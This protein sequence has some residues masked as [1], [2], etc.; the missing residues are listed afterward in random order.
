MNHELEMKK[1]HWCCLAALLV[2]SVLIRTYPLF[3]YS[4][5]GTD[6]GEYVYY[7]HRWIESGSMHRSID[8]WAQAYPF[9]PGIFCL[10]GAFHLLTGVN[11]HGSVSTAPIALSLLTPLLIF[12]VVH[13]IT[14]QKNMALLSAALMTFFA[15]I[16]YNYSQPKPETLGFF[17]M[18]FLLWMLFIT[19]KENLGKMLV[20]I[21]PFSG[22]LVITHHLSSLFLILLTLGGYFF[23]EMFRTR[24]TWENRFRAWF[25]V[26]FST[27][28][29]AYWFYGAPPFRDERFLGAMGLPSY[30]ILLAPYIAFFMAFVLIRA[31][32]LSIVWRPGIDLRGNEFKERIFLSMITS[33]IVIFILIYSVYSHIPG[34]DITLGSNILLG[35][36]LLLVGVFALFSSRFLYMFREGTLLMG[37]I[38]VVI[39]TVILGILTGSSSL[40][41][42]RLVSFFMLPLVIL[43]GIGVIRFLQLADPFSQK[44]KV[45]AA[46]ILLLLAVNIPLMY[47]SQETTSGYIE[48]TEHDALEASHWTSYSIHGNILTD[49]RL[50]AALFSMGELNVSWTDGEPAYF[51]TS[52]QEAHET[53]TAMGIRYIM[54]DHYMIETATVADGVNPAPMDPELVRWYH[55]GYRLYVRENTEVYLIPM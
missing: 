18:V 27:A 48:W 16:V 1:Y 20:M 49:H 12:L 28:T 14:F 22:A 41:T 54:M 50:S 36:P 4:L 30:S 8:G 6:A 45:I 33:V 31:R 24:T 21:I 2:L 5:W 19:N 10:S 3:N 7:T 11:V 35:I 38:A 23:S 43:F 17:L 39:L 51:S 47:P 37:W 40:Y 52:R 9:F 26:A 13:R 29:L 34:T 53:L 46:C 25:Y 32:R 55:S 15:P 42:I 44:N